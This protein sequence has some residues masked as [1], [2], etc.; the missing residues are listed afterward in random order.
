ML[1]SHAH[2]FIFFHIRKTGGTS[3]AAALSGVA[4]DPFRERHL[5]ASHVR[6]RMPTEFNTY[7]KWSIA[8]NPFDRMVSMFSYDSHVTKSFQPGGEHHGYDF[9]QYLQ[10]R[11]VK[12]R[13]HWSSPQVD[14]LRDNDTWLVDFT[15]RF[16]NLQRDF[17]GICDKL[18]MQLMALPNKRKTSH[19]D[20][21]TYY[22]DASRALVADTFERDLLAFGYEF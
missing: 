20:Y 11:L 14:F 12:D 19:G 16:E 9:D 4:D 15:A 3:V 13:G 10:L 22:D 21:H 17:D 7:F 8:R 1:V 2:K 18:G 5:R 6:E